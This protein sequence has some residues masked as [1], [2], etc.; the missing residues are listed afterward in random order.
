MRLPALH[1]VR[2]WSPRWYAVIAVVMA[3]LG[4]LACGPGAASAPESTLGLEVTPAISTGDAPDFNVETFN[5]GAFSLSGKTGSPVVINFWFPSCPPCRAEMPDL[6]EA[7]EKYGPMGVEF[8]GV[9]QLGLDTGEDGR[10]FLDDLGITYPNF[11][12]MTN[13]V[14]L[15]YRVLAYPTTVFLD[16]EHNIVRSWTGQIGQDDLEEQIERILES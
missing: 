15:A 14:Q 12:D 4:A 10:S 8:V 7:Y 13:K 2:A 5:H 3:A 6:Q 9:Q 11:P 16:R 1:R